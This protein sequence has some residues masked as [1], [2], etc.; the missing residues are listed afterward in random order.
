MR[1]LAISNL[2]PPTTLGGYEL[3]AS[4]VCREL[5]RRGHEVALCS[6]SRYL[7]AYTTHY[8]DVPCPPPA[9]LRW[10][11]AGTAVF[12]V[13]L[14][15]LIERGYPAAFDG[16]LLAVHESLVA[17]PGVI[18]E[19]H[20]GVRAFAPNVILLFNPAGLLVSVWHEAQAALARRVPTVAYVSDDWPTRWPASQPLGALARE[21]AQ[22]H[23]TAGALAALLTE[24]GV[25]P[26][27]DFILPDEVA[28][29]SAFLRER[30]GTANLG[31][32]C[33]RVI[34]WG[35]PAVDAIAPIDASAFASP[36]PLTLAFCGQV[37]HHKGLAELLR[38]LP[39]T[40]RPHRL[41]VIGD[42]TT[43]YG[44]TCQRLVDASGLT[45]RVTFTGKLAPDE[46]VD[47]LRRHAHLLVVPSLR[48]EGTFEEPFSIAVLQGM[49]LGLM[50]IGTP[51]GGTPE[52][53]VDGVHGRLVDATDAATLASAIDDVEADRS[54][55]VRMARAAR[56]RVEQSF[57]V[58]V[59]A[60]AI[61]Q[62]LE[63]RPD[64]ADRTP[65]ARITMVVTN[66]AKDPANSG[67]VRVT[68]QLAR[69]LAARGDV[70]LWLVAWNAET[71]RWQPL[72]P[73]A[74]DMLARFDGPSPAARAH[75]VASDT[76]PAG[77][78][79]LLPEILEEH[80]AAAIRLQARQRGLHV[81][82]I[83]YDAIPH[84]HP[85]LCSATLRDRH[86]G[87]MR[88]LAACDR[89]LAISVAAAR[90]LEAFW[91]S[92]GISGPSVDIIPLAG[93]PGCRAG[94][95]APPKSSPPGRHEGV[96]QLLCVSTLE[97]RKNHGRLLAALRDISE[98][99]PDVQWS[100]V[101]VGNRYAGDDTI[102]TDVERAC[103]TDPRITWRGVVNDDELVTL[104]ERA[105]ATVYPSEVEGFGLPIVE[106]LAHGRPVLCG[107]HGALGELAAGGG[108]LA[109][110]V[111]D[112]SALRDGL[113]QLLVDADL[114]AR[115]A[116][117]ALRR[118]VRTWDAYA[119]DVAAVLRPLPN[120]AQLPSRLTDALYAGLKAEH[121]QM[122]HA[123]RLA[124]LRVL[125]TLRPT[126]A[127]EVGTYRGGSLS[128]MARTCGIVFSID[129]DP[130]VAR[131]FADYDN[132]R[133]LTGS[134]QE[135]LPVLLR[136]LAR[137]GLE[138]EFVLIDGSHATA[139]VVADL[140]PFLDV[141]PRR[142]MTILVHDSAHPP[143]RRA[144]SLVPWERSPYVSA[145][146][147][148]FVPGSAHTALTKPPDELYGGLGLIRL[149][150]V[151]RAHP[152][153]ITTGAMRQ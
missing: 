47:A 110:D 111:T 94:R 39:L 66:A 103:A 109:V 150:P 143:C 89:V 5:A 85:H 116:D 24:H 129:I 140:S 12:G 31:H 73:P 40:R 34:P 132:V 146:E 16:L 107:R 30:V 11:D 28:F 119:E 83:F 64:A 32:S 151:P 57:T 14:P 33:A 71:R 65:T 127:I 105:W 60:D 77:G 18:R 51:T 6:A 97:P 128:A 21:G 27:Q 22:A 84:T 36:A 62:R 20:D 145:V 137:A 59:M 50:V 67:C 135:L 101:L 112:I 3:G 19:L 49:A 41:V 8:V 130:G 37:L 142:P 54:S 61:E 106:S 115:L 113:L 141:I 99:R 139:D 100:L 48:L 10:I 87:H 88:G 74:R 125:E 86:A 43:D 53:I 131:R 58:E 52:A 17:A 136:E 25:R 123:E 152:I 126:C 134:S 96:A 92:A 35:L 91:A 138:P 70:D 68:R 95:D 117:E 90:D 23:P 13:D 121:W 108:C 7:W 29:C 102:A 149:D 1:I 46:V 144:F 81:A 114:H 82:A 133:F 45:N 69:T 26:P 44:V 118:P 79:L 4:W 75:H 56:H 120:A 76:A 122:N 55:A 147:L 153:V 98:S 9:D 148:D 93:S 38:A 78:W 72:A 15:R 124:F 80:E 42:H 104:Y 63:R 2:F